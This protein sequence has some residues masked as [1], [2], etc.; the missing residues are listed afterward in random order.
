MPQTRRFSKQHVR[1]RLRPF[2]SV[3]GNRQLVFSLSCAAGSLCV[4]MFAAAWWNARSAR[5]H[6]ER[7]AMEL[8]SLDE[9]RQQLTVD[10]AVRAEETAALR[11]RLVTQE[12]ADEFRN[13]VIGLIRE[14][15]CRLR[16]VTPGDHEVRRW[17][18]D[19]DLATDGILVD[20]FEDEPVPTPYSL[21]TQSLNVQVSGDFE[22]I[23]RLVD[24]VQQL[25]RAAHTRSLVVQTDGES[26]LTLDWDLLFYDLE[27]TTVAYDW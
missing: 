24:A 9:Q 8:A 3:R 23:R 18:E 5:L 15:G 7:H 2:F 27:T 22:H 11:T 26:G 19:D 16:N 10:V 21:V 14:T 6:A 20:D 17:M 4:V 1:D 25:Q 13:Q 12:S